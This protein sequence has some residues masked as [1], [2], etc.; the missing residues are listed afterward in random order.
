MLF[1]MTEFDELEQEY[2]SGKLDKIKSDLEA[3]IKKYDMEIKRFV[4]KINSEMHHKISIDQGIRWYLT[5]NQSIN[6][7]NESKDQIEEIKKEIWYRREE[8]SQKPEEEI[9]KDWIKK[10]AR[11]WRSHRILQTVYA[12]SQEK[13]KYLKL[14]EST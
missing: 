4:Q 8:H 9:A 13:E 3:F 5:L 12:Y 6:L 11:G 14:L 7:T 10:H 1:G 2:K